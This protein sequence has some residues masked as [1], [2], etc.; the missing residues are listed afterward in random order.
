M[1]KCKQTIVSAKSPDNA[2]SCPASVSPAFRSSSSSFTSLLVACAQQSAEHARARAHWAHMQEWPQSPCTACCVGA[3]ACMLC[4]CPCTSANAR[5]IMADHAFLRS[6]AL[7]LLAFCVLYTLWDKSF[8]RLVFLGFILDVACH[9]FVPF[10]P[11]LVPVHLCF[12]R[13]ALEHHAR[14][15]PGGIVGACLVALRVR[16][17]LITGTRYQ[18]CVPRAREAVRLSG[19]APN[20]SRMTNISSL[21]FSHA[22]CSPVMPT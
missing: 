4:V 18:A 21:A 17:V 15:L 11:I 19:S 5:S 2:N 8:S 1:S 16:H 9:T 7:A 22:I 20:L 10:G 13:Q 12:S 6:H 14:R 3:Y